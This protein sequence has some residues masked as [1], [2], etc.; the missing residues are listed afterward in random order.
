MSV[1]SSVFPESWPFC[2]SFPLS[3]TGPAM[4][5]TPLKH[6]GPEP[7]FPL[8]HAGG[9]LGLF[10]PLGD[11]HHDMIHISSPYLPDS[12]PVPP[13]PCPRLFSLAPRAVGARWQVHWGPSL[14]CAS[15]HH[16]LSLQPLHLCAGGT[17]GPGSPQMAAAGC[18]LLAAGA[19]AVPPAA[20]HLLSQQHPLRP[21]VGRGQ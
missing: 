10:S 12:L 7:S 1:L 11:G 2:L 14:L 9:R 4:C 6:S 15:P 16:C 17:C 19:G 18:V 3:G 13:H 5:G 20:A 21:A 8:S